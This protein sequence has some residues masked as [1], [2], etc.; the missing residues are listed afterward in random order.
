MSVKIQ[1]FY[2]IVSVVKNKLL[3]H[4]GPHRDTAK[5][6]LILNQTLYI[7]NYFNFKKVILLT[8]F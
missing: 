4:S 2:N 8:H 6:T 3:L 7:I 1:F 5:L